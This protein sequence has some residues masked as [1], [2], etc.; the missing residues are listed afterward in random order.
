MVLPKTLN[1][2]RNNVIIYQDV[3]QNNGITLNVTKNKFFFKRKPCFLRKILI[4]NTFFDRLLCSG[5]FVCTISVTFARLQYFTALGT[6]FDFK[7][8]CFLIVPF[9]SST[10]RA[11][12]LAVYSSIIYEQW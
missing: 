2:Q 8:F 4:I 11:Y 5:K 10:V 1:E 9:G 6:Y 12:I 3:S 7:F